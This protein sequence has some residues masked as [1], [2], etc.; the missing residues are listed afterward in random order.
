MDW[1][2][3]VTIVS[4]SI[5]VLCMVLCWIVDPTRER[6]RREHDSRESHRIDGVHGGQ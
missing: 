2:A 6:K 5:I 3:Y 1:L 4:F